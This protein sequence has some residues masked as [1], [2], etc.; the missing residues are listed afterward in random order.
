MPLTVR[1]ENANI[2]KY[3]P[4]TMLSA[5]CLLI[6]VDQTKAQ[7]REDR[8]IGFAKKINVSQLDVGLPQQ[9]FDEWFR[10][11]VGSEAIVVWELND[12]G[13]QTGSE[14]DRK[15]DLPTCAQAEAKLTDGRKVIVMIAIGTLK[16]GLTG[17][18][19][20]FDLVIEHEGQFSTVKHLSELTKEI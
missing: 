15:R 7:K 5:L 20:V 2:M 13:E 19:V 11:L 6:L 3:L 1:G 10:N 9:K 8:E 17:R 14:A 16:K 4:A 12:C 18:P